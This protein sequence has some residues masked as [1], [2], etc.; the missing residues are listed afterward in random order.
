MSDSPTT[1]TAPKRP[2][3]SHAVVSEHTMNINENISFLPTVDT[4]FEHPVCSSVLP[5]RTWFV[6]KNISCSPTELENSD[7]ITN[8]QYYNLKS[9]GMNREKKNTKV[10][11]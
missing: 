4:V 1:N 3:N 11:I 5:E 6:N 7:C 2:I 9:A 8:K 10:V